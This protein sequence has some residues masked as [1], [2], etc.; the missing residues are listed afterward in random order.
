[1]SNLAKDARIY[2]C[3]IEHSDKV[4][5]KKQTKK[6]RKKEKRKKK[7]KRHQILNSLNSWDKFQNNASLLRRSLRVRA[8]P[9][10]IWQE[11]RG[12]PARA[13]NY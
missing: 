3:I 9:E 5:K 11:H 12:L 6:K 4:V 13:G 2:S 7:K 10:A 8:H 1:M